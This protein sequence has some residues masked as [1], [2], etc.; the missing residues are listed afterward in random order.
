MTDAYLGRPSPGLMSTSPSLMC[1]LD[2]RILTRRLSSANWYHRPGRC[3]FSQSRSP[4]FSG[5]HQCRMACP[6]QLAGRA[7]VSGAGTRAA[8]NSPLRYHCTTISN[9]YW[10][11]PGSWVAFATPS[12]WFSLPK[13]TK[14]NLGFGL[15]S[16]SSE[17]LPRAA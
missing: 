10:F 14:K 2:R 8:E 13:L 1:V 16:S 9:R 11:P 12:H 3:A 15:I 4:D 6:R 7:P 17:V 5:A